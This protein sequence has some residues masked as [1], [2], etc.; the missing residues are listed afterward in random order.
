M[1]EIFIKLDILY[2]TGVIFCKYN[3]NII[4]TIY[5]GNVFTPTKYLGNNL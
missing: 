5:L 1:D 2:F 4:F 3:L